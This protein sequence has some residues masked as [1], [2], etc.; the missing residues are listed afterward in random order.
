MV[1]RVKRLLATDTDVQV[2]ANCLSVLMQVRG[3][4]PDA[5]GHAGLPKAGLSPFVVTRA[6][7]SIACLFG[8]GAPHVQLEPTS[9]LVEK[10]LV[11]SL[12]NRIKVR[13]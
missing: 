7:L 9:R 1:D 5:C 2:I 10:A 8:L 11:Y 13:R 6:V 3:R 4:V 12:M